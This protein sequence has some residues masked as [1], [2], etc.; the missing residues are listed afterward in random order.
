M[1]F[2]YFNFGLSRGIRPVKPVERCSRN[3]LGDRRLLL[4]GVLRR[5]TILRR[6]LRLI[7]IDVNHD[8]R[9]I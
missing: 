4:P 7:A 8:L 2:G 5:P 9:V 3:A 6:K 1:F